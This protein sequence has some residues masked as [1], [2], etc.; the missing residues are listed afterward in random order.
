MLNKKFIVGQGATGAEEP[1]EEATSHKRLR[2]TRLDSILLPF[3]FHL[4]NQL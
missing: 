2:T 3:N 1:L 4:V